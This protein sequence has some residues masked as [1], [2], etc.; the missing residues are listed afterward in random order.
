MVTKNGEIQPYR[1]DPDRDDAASTSSAVLLGDINF[2]D[3]D[4]PAYEDTP[5][6]VTEAS[7]AIPARNADPFMSWYWYVETP[8]LSA[9]IPTDILQPSS[10]P[11]LQQ[12]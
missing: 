8:L 6:V 10:R 4:L 9:R 12:P 7:S 1:D 5:S 3:E 11:P 2:P